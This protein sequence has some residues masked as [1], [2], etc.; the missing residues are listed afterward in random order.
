MEFIFEEKRSFST[1]CVIDLELIA[2]VVSECSTF[3]AQTGLRRTEEGKISTGAAET[4]EVQLGHAS[5]KKGSVD[6]LH[7]SQEDSNKAATPLEIGAAPESTVL[8][9]PAAKLATPSHLGLAVE[10]GLDAGPETSCPR[11]I[12]RPVAAAEQQAYEAKLKYLVPGELCPVCNKKCYKALF[13]PSR[14]N[15]YWMLR[16]IEYGH[17]VRE[18]TEKEIRKRETPHARRSDAELLT[19]QPAKRSHGGQEGDQI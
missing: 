13:T 7:V 8:A 17:H 5:D 4:T 16:C 15:P 12:R 10:E 6:A 9:V 3:V 14:G 11:Q 1:A 2:S 19:E 18:L